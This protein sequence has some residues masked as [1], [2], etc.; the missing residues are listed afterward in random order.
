MKNKVLWFVISI[1]IIGFIAFIISTFFYQVATVYGDSML[2]TYK[3]G[4]MVIVKKN[5][6]KIDRDDIII[7][8]KNKIT[9]I[10]RVVGIPHD[11]LIIKDNKLYVNDI[12]NE[13]FTDIKE[14]GVLSEEI[15]LKNNEYFVLGDNVNYSVDSRYKGFGIIDKS[16]IDGIVID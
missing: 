5:Y 6:S 13:K 10:K 8:K 9:F 14:S 4:S 11:K 16:L 7:G 15:E 3:N 12:L 1:S 2:P